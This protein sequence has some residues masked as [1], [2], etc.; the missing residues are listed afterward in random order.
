MFLKRWIFS[1]QYFVYVDIYI[2]IY[3]F[4]V[5]CFFSITVDERLEASFR[6]NTRN[7]WQ[8]RE[9]RNKQGSYNAMPD[10]T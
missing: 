9:S 1:H 6:Q 2:N 8:R 3:V 7:G 4:C 5:A 10:C